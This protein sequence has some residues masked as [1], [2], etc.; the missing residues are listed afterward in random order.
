MDWSKNWTNCQ[1]LKIRLDARTEA[2]KEDVSGEP[3]RMVTLQQSPSPSKW[4]MLQF[5]QHPV[6][7]MPSKRKIEEAKKRQSRIKVT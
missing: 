3:G 6:K 1:F 7:H 4:Q 5:W 2:Q